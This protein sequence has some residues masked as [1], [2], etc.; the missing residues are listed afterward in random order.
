MHIDRASRL[1][2]GSIDSLP[3]FEVLWHC[4]CMFLKRGKPVFLTNV[5]E[6]NAKGW[7]RHAQI[8]QRGK[9]LPTLD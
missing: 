8:A 4:S 9:G 5:C 1:T 6:A 3:E 7:E 2:S